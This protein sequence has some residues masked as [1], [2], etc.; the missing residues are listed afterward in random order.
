LGLVN[1]ERRQAAAGSSPVAAIVN[2][3]HRH[4]LLLSLKDDTQIAVTWRV[5]G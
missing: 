1:I 4:L 2:I 5:E 3:H